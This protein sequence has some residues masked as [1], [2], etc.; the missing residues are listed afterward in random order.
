MAAHG[1]PA[2]GA[3][4]VSFATRFPRSFAV[5][6][7]LLVRRAWLAYARN[8]GLNF[9]RLVALTILALVFG[10]VYYR[11]AS[12]ADT[13]GG[14]QSLVAAI[15]MATAFSALI[16]MNTAVPANIAARAVFYREIAARAYQ[17]L[18]YGLATVTVE[19]PWLA[20]LVFVALPIYYFM[21]GLSASPSVF[22]FT[23]LVT[24]VLCLV[25]FS[26]GVFIA[27]SLPTFEVAQVRAP[28]AATPRP[29]SCTHSRR[30]PTP[31]RRCLSLPLKRRPSSASSARCFSS[32]EACGRRRRR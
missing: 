24:Y 26:L 21:Y 4:A 29:A 22:F 1:A 28:L 30:L 6:Y 14:V 25:Y 23:Y 9:G 11:I 15:F 31:R 32:L 13:L 20:G 18:A 27:T 3:A 19:L 7:A 12:K 5:Q 17:P 8:V 16:N 2:A 10:T